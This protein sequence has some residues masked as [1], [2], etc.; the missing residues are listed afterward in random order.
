MRLCVRYVRRAVFCAVQGGAMA[1]ATDPRAGGAGSPA[2][3]ARAAGTS[4]APNTVTEFVLPAPTALF[5]DL[6]GVIPDA[7]ARMLE[8][9]LRMVRRVTAGEIV[10]VTMKT[11]PGVSAQQ[12]SQRIGNEWRI[13]ARGG[14]TRQAGAVVLLIPKESSA[15]G[16]GHCRIELGNGA[17]AFIPDSA[18]ATMCENAVS[19][20][21]VRAY[22]TGLR[23]IVGELTRRYVEAIRKP[24][25]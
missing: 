7:T 17:S 12:M 8:D 3:P 6:A 23:A 19:F 18:A 20:F 15:D 16:R 1:C 21:R 24:A 13:G 5:T 10:V 2:T 14:Q 11:L 22:A 4:A 25:G 9:S